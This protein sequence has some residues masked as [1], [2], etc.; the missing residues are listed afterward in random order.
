[1]SLF[2]KSQLKKSSESKPKNEPPLPDAAFGQSSC[3]IRNDKN[4]SIHNQNIEFL[5]QCNENEIIQERQRLL[6]NMGERW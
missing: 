3:I 5:K 2:A 6:E 4:N 1:M